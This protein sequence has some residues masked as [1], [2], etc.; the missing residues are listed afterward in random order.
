VGIGVLEVGKESGTEID[1]SVI[2]EKSSL[3]TLFEVSL[4]KSKVGSAL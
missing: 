4:K 1:V 3:L 2:E